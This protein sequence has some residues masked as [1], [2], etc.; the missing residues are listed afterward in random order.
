MAAV[1][2]FH[3]GRFFDTEGWHV[4]SPRTNEMASFFTLIL[5]I[6]Y[7]EIR[8]DAPLWLEYAIIV[9]TSFA[10]TV[11]L[12]ELLIKRLNLLRFSN[13]AVARNRFRPPSL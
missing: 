9:L 8:L 6:G 10:A 7:R 5:A 1:F 11:A 13:P 3:C 2:L 4:K 12:D